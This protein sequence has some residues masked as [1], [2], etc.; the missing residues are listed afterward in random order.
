MN[1]S[2]VMIGQ[3]NF[4]S[5]TDPN[6]IAEILIGELTVIIELIAPSKRVQCK[7]TYVPWLN[8]EY[9]LE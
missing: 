8:Y 7:S 6:Q 4:F 2:P 1:T 9:I 5:H 3:M